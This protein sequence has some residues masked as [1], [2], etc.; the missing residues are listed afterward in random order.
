MTSTITLPATFTDKIEYAGDHWLWVG[1]LSGGY[2]V[3]KHDGK[4]QGAH[5]VAYQLTKGAIPDGHQID[6]L[7]RVP[8]CVN[9]DHLEAVTPH[10]NAAR[11]PY[12]SAGKTHCK[13]GHELSGDNLYINKITGARRCRTCKRKWDAKYRERTTA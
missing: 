7:C 11:S 5:R 9:P 12:T 6:H 13:N 3:Y 8:S 10:E 1:A 4:I 2:G